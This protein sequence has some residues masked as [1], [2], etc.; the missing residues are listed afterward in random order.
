MSTI[1]INTSIITPLKNIE[2]KIFQFSK[3]QKISQERNIFRSSNFRK[4]RWD[5]SEHYS[6]IRTCLK[7]G[8]KWNKVYL[9]FN[10]FRFKKIL[11]QDPQPKLDPTLKIM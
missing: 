5:K 10:I 11:K 7:H 2:N 8:S 4:G 6:F 3:I 1:F 9:T